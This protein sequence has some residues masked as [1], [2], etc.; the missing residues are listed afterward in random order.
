MCSPD[1][2]NKHIQYLGGINYYGKSSAYPVAY[3]QAELRHGKG[4]IS[5]AD[6]ITSH[7]HQAGVMPWLSDDCLSHA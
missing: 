6:R 2:K 5:T 1:R 3:H 4:E 7:G